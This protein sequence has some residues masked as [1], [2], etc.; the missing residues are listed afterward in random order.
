[1]DRKKIFEHV[2]TGASKAAV[3]FSEFKSLV[4]RS[5]FSDIEEEN[6]RLKSMP[7]TGE[8]SL[9]SAL[10]IKTDARTVAEVVTAIPA[11]S[12]F[13]SPKEQGRAKA[14]DLMR[15]EIELMKKTISN[16]ERSLTSG[17]TGKETAEEYTSTIP[18]IDRIAGAANVTQR[19]VNS[20]VKTFTRSIAGSGPSK[21]IDDFVESSEGKAL[22]KLLKGMKVDTP[23]SR[24]IDSVLGPVLTKMQTQD[25]GRVMDGLDSVDIPEITSRNIELGTVT[26]YLSNTE[27]MTELEM[28]AS[29]NPYTRFGLFFQLCLLQQPDFISKVTT[30]VKGTKLN[31][32]DFV[33]GG[34]PFEE[35]LRTLFGR[36][37]DLAAL[38]PFM[39]SLNELSLSMIDSTWNTE[40]FDRIKTALFV[41]AMQV[42]YVALMNFVLANAL[43]LF[44]TKKGDIV[45]K[46]RS[47]EAEKLRKEEEAKKA[48]SS[49]PW[50]MGDAD[51]GKKIA[52]LFRSAPLKAMISDNVIY[53]PGKSGYDPD[54]VK[55]LKELVYYMFGGKE[56]GIPSVKAWDVSKNPL[57]GNYDQFFSNIIKDIQTKYEIPPLR[58]GQGDGK[59]GPVTKKFF[60][61]TTP[62]AISDLV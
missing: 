8:D 59:V 4:E 45:T 61:K 26:D 60:A 40:E 37:A 29:M 33:S 48:A 34:K 43:Y 54:K 3:K 55:A 12:P 19:M 39:A 18:N 58:N 7:L 6:L 23:T 16:F 14:M 2:F 25:F 24:I 44:L 9:M 50:T 21:T 17:I 13:F 10:N 36:N 31:Y 49:T 28:A 11:F 35:S 20:I 57:D 38:D 46:A 30:D 15:A 22:I 32:P 56:S 41:P 52:A 47:A 53:V 42:F 27:E 51:R 1:M 5:D 62:L